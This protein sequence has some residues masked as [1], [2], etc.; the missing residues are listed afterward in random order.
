[1]CRIILRLMFLLVFLRLLFHLSMCTL[2]ADIDCFQA[3]TWGCM[4]RILLDRLRLGCCLFFVVRYY[5]CM[6]SLRMLF[7][8]CDSVGRMIDIVVLRLFHLLLLR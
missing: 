4:I 3:Q 8:P 1:M 6:Y 5:M 2:L 7:R